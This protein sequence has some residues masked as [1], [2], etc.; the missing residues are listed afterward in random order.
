MKRLRTPVGIVLLGL[1]TALIF[2]VPAF[3]QQKDA[4]VT[5]TDTRIE[6]HPGTKISESDQKALSEVLKKYDKALYK[7]ETLTDG[8][9]TG[10]VQGKLADQYIDAALAAEVKQAK[11]AGVSDTTEQAVDHKTTTFPITAAAVQNEAQ[12]KELIEALKPILEKY[13]KK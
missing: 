11:T 13:S 8:K 3:A 6:I 2:A 9:V 1:G 10:H 4:Q 5:I 12:V 7:I